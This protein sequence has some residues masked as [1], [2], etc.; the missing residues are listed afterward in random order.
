MNFLSLDCP[1]RPFVSQLLFV[2]GAVVE[3]AVREQGYF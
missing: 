1:F 3:F 2:R